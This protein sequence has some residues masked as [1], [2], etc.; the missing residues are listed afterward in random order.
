MNVIRLTIPGIITM[1]F[2]VGST[3]LAQV[4]RH[5]DQDES[6]IVVSGAVRAP[7]RIKLFRQAR[8][9]EIIAAAGGLTERAE[10]TVKLIET[11]SKCYAEAW[12]SSKWPDHPLKAA[13][14][15]LA[16]LSSG[17][18]NAD[19][20]V[21][22]GD[23][24]EVVELDPIYIAGN[25]SN[26]RILYSRKPPTVLEAITLAGGIPK[27]TKNLRVV[28]LR[29]NERGNYQEYLK[30]ELSKLRKHPARAPRLRGM[31]I[32]NVGDLKIIRPQMFP[33][34]DSRPMPSRPI[35]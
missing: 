32:V 31:D 35:F 33:F 16:G 19:P 23:V 30:T 13:E 34:F 12:S 26:P 2:A 10:G 25:V 20:I 24:I 17:N 5:P 22:A 3:S 27:E 8:L 21:H 15:P 6:C 18:E 4:S 28:V 14:L 29:R 7:G 1:A 9:H 11:G